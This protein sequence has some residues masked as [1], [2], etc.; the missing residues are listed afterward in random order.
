[1][2]RTGKGCALNLSLSNND[3]I[4][5]MHQRTEACECD[6]R[7]LSLFRALLVFELA[8]EGRAALVVRPVHVERLARRV[9][10]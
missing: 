3:L 2:I 9:G 7:I 10:N 6:P 4:L 8:R 1:M 5:I